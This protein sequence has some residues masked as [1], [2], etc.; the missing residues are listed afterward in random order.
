M[1]AVSEREM[2]GARA[3]DVEHLRMLEGV[4]VAF[5]AARLMMTW[6]PAGIVTPPSSTGSTVYRNVECGTGASKRRSSSNAGCELPRI[7]RSAAS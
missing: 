3:V 2:A 1:D 6:A 7:A 4:R 5:A